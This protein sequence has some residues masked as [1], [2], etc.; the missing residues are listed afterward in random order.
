MPIPCLF[1]FFTETEISILIEAYRRLN[2]ASLS[3]EE[4][5]MLRKDA[6]D[7]YIFLR[8]AYEQSR[9]KLIEE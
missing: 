6:L 8:D 9:D 3:L 2:D 1:L 7:L 4:Y 5:V